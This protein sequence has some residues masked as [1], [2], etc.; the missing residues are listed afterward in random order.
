MDRAGTRVFMEIIEW[1]LNNGFVSKR[2]LSAM[3]GLEPM[4]RD[5]V[6]DIDTNAAFQVYDR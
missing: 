6:L 4:L 1:Q 5:T 2:C 3:R